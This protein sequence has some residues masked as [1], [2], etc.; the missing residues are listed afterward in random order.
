VDLSDNLI[1]EFDAMSDEDF[2]VA[3]YR[4]PF[5]VLV[6]LSRVERP[7]LRTVVRLAGAHMALSNLVEAFEL[8]EIALRA[9]PHLAPT[10]AVRARMIRGVIGT[11]LRLTDRYRVDFFEAQRLLRQ[12]DIDPTGEVGVALLINWAAAQGTTGHIAAAARTLDLAEAAA[13]ALPEAVPLRAVRLHAIDFNRTILTLPPEDSLEQLAQ[14]VDRLEAAGVFD[15]AGRVHLD[16]A[17]VLSRNE[18]Y[19]AALHHAAQSVRL[20][21]AADQ[22]LAALKARLHLAHVVDNLGLFDQARQMVL[23]AKPPIDSSAARVGE[24]LRQIEIAVDRER[25]AEFDAVFAALDTAYGLLFPLIQ[26]APGLA[27]TEVPIDDVI[28]HAL[29]TCHK[30]RDASMRAE[31]S[32][33]ADRCARLIGAVEQGEPHALIL[34]S[35]VAWMNED[36]EEAD[37]VMARLADSAAGSAIPGAAAKAAALAGPNPSAELQR[38]MEPLMNAYVGGDPTPVTDVAEYW[39]HV[40]HLTGEDDE[41]IRAAYRRGN[42]LPV[43]HRMLS[44]GQ[45]EPLG[46]FEA[47]ELSRWGSLAGGIGVAATTGMPMPSVFGGPDRRLMR[48][49]FLRRVAGTGAPYP[50]SLGTPRSIAW[51]R[52]GGGILSDPSQLPWCPPSVDLRRLILEGDWPEEPECYQLY[53]RGQRGHWTYLDPATERPERGEFILPE[54]VLDV[55]QR[56]VGWLS[57]A[58]TAMDYDLIARI[59]ADAELLSATSAVRCCLGPFVDSSDLARDFAVQL[60]R[61]LQRALGPLAERAAE[62]CPS[63][64][65]FAIAL[66][67]L[68]P[69]FLWEQST[70][71]LLLSLSAELAQL[72]VM[73]AVNDAGTRLGLARSI[74]LLPPINTLADMPRPTLNSTV[75]RWT[76]LAAGISGTDLTRTNQ[77]EST[78][79]REAFLRPPGAAATRSAVLYKGHYAAVAGPPSRARLGGGRADDEFLTAAEILASTSASPAR[80]ALMCCRGAGLHFR[81]EW[82]GIASALMIKGTR[83]LLAPSWPIIDGPAAAVVDDRFSELLARPGHLSDHFA[84]VTR[85]LLHD[86]LSG[87]PNAIAP[88]WWSGYYLFKG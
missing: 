31:W 21:E 69:P 38:L 33:R 48:S 42:L 27:V 11:T 9:G 7:S 35:L 32:A 46:Q 5:T 37:R 15:L 17:K 61:P 75:R 82:G 74:S 62:E 87:S 1:R 30:T 6:A 18:L 70:R 84:E 43:L 45:L 50:A 34:R 65:E 2:M 12:Y 25:L 24:A 63:P 81:D 76:V 71:P 13:Q 77:S 56:T 28:T 86:W 79:L 85:S 72:P 80:G 8:S 78:P 59:G 16:L 44:K 3:C 52:W 36:W 68:F 4:K 49:A 26:R 40:R 39:D 14:T 10:D 20:F 41:I 23:D 53:L 64:T 60:P 88:H 22:P 19:T 83:E 66:G 57:P 73:L 58:P 29:L 47:V 55:I 54:G 67:R 51:G